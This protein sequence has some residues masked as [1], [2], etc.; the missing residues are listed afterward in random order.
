MSIHFSEQKVATETD[1]LAEAKL[2]CKKIFAWRKLHPNDIGC[3]ELLPKIQSDH[4]DFSHSYPLVI[5]YMT[6]GEYKSKGFGAFIK[7]I[8]VE[9]G[10]IGERIKPIGDPQA[11]MEALEIENL[12]VQA[13]YVVFLYKYTKPH[14]TATHISN[15]RKNM[16]DI[17]YKEHFEFKEALKQSQGKVEELEKILAECSKDET[18]EYY[19]S[20][21][22]HIIPEKIE[23][24]VD[25]DIAANSRE[26]LRSGNASVQT[27]VQTPV[28][29][30]TSA[31]NTESQNTSRLSADVFLD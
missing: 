28:Q 19:K 4:K 11:R 26:A 9:H 30:P 12:N 16:R 17:L 6:M 15:L 10:R 8:Q 31:Q 1:L 14:Y 2:I 7:W 3:L 22:L 20:T 5:R 13:E 24:F 29:M 23:V 27:P 18:R 25:P 21:R